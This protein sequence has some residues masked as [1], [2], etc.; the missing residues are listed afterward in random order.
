MRITIVGAG[1]IGGSAGA[2]LTAAGQDVL[3]VDRAADH[4]AAM[5]DQGLRITG[6]RGERVVRVKAC[7]PAD[8]EGPLEFVII[9]VK[10]Q[11]T[12]AALETVVPL[13]APHGFTYGPAKAKQ[14]LA[15][16]GYPKAGMAYNSQAMPS[17]S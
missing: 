3:L 15:P 2:Y 12:A 5:N 13:L 6:V 17:G 8:L 10:G 1:A 16:A 14:L 4:V 11:F 9:A 7:T